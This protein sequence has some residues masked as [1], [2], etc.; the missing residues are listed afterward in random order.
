M[1]I[2][3]STPG[4]LWLLLSV[5][6]VAVLFFGL[7]LV[8][9][10]TG[11]PKNRRNKILA[12]VTIAIVA[13]IILLANLSAIGF[14]SDFSKI[15]PR[16][17]FLILIPFPIVLGF[18]LSKAGGQILKHTPPHW[19][20]LMQ[21]FRILVEILIWI[22]FLRK[23][24]PV[25]MTFEGGNLDILTGLLAIPVGYFL[26]KKPGLFP[27]MAYAF[28]IIGSV[29]LINVLIIA[30]LSMPSPI[31][32]FMNEPSIRIVGEFPFVLL[33]GVMVPIAYSL[34]ILSFRQSFLWSR[35]RRQFIT[36]ISQTKTVS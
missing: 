29:F 14:F 13:W 31:R 34:H 15:P 28:N 2:S 26:W 1:K 20:V 25:Q 6:C 24:L 21:S 16:P 23:L 9:G 3:F 35:T 19:L 32:Y 22:G 10:R 33:P 36:N 12:I 11:W 18:A 8:L 7:N 27:K 4:I 5:A 30:V 17:V